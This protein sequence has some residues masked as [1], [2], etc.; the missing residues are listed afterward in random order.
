[1]TCGVCAGLESPQGNAWPGPEHSSCRWK[2]G[3]VPA[4][5]LSLPSAYQFAP[6][7]ARICSSQGIKTS[8]Q[9]ASVN[10]TPRACSGFP[11]CNTAL[12]HCNLNLLLLNYHSKA[13]PF[14][15]TSGFSSR[16][17]QT[18]CLV[19]LQRYFNKCPCP[20]HITGRFIYARQG[21]SSSGIALIFPSCY[22]PACTD[23]GQKEVA[24]FPV[25]DGRIAEQGGCR[26]SMAITGCWWTQ[27]PDFS[28]QG[29]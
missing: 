21:A 28:G 15:E 24:N 7:L 9:A 25:K 22:L 29:V 20:G 8:L 26:L 4:H 6:K 10:S 16:S 5:C 17:K 11:Q 18:D 2:G 27:G 19:C 14:L 23:S 12:L 1:M 3:M 13:S